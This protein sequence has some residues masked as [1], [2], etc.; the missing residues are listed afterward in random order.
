MPF[1]AK[2]SKLNSLVVLYVPYEV[3]AALVMISNGHFDSSQHISILHAVYPK[4]DKISE[5]SSTNN[6]ITSAR[7]SNMASVEL[8]YDKTRSTSDFENI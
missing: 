8:Q 5:K 3:I 6:F 2:H 1:S 7:Y 4:R